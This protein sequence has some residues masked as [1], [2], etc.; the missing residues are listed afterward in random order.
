MPPSGPAGG[1]IALCAGAVDGTPHRSRQRI[2]SAEPR[3]FRPNRTG[4]SETT[5]NQRAAVN[6]MNANSHKLREQ[7]QH[8]LDDYVSRLRE[9]GFG[10]RNEFRARFNASRA[11]RDEA[12]AELFFQAWPAFTPDLLSEC[13]AC[14]TSCKIQWWLLKRREDEA[15]R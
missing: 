10:P 5:E 6:A 13:D 12:A 3:H 7:I 2:A 15:L 9:A 1:G 4:V 11:L 14:V 8:S